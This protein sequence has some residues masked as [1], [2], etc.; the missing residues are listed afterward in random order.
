MVNLIPLRFAGFMVGGF[1]VGR[2]TRTF[3]GNPDADGGRLLPGHPESGQEQEP[4]GLS[5]A[6]H[7]QAAAPSHESKS[8]P[9]PLKLPPRGES[10]RRHFPAPSGKPEFRA[11]GRG[12]PESRAGPAGKSRVRPRRGKR[13]ARKTG[14]V[15]T[16][17]AAAVAVASLTPRRERVG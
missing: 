8:A 17:A 3:A 11:G 4:A 6:P 12:S 10:P 16:G 9:Q 14:A 13:P 5:V 2:I 1:S 15:R 7:L